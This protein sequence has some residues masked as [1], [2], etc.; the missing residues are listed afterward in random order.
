MSALTS[1]GGQRS[2]DSCISIFG[3]CLYKRSQIN[4]LIST[5]R[6]PVLSDQRIDRLANL[7]PVLVAMVTDSEPYLLV[8]FLLRCL[9]SHQPVTNKLESALRLMM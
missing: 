6:D 8:F 9:L 3:T 5:V 1:A 4:V 7:N 2:P